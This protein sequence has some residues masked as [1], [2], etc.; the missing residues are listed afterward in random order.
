MSETTSAA[1]ATNNTITMIDNSTG[2]RY[3]LPILKGT[4]GPDVVDVRKLY[5]DT[6]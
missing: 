2:R 6:G 1:Q 5:Q 3:E 4:T